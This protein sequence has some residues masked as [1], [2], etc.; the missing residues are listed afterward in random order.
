MQLVLLRHADVDVDLSVPAPL[1]QLSDLGRADVRRLARAPFWRRLERIFTSPEPKALETAQI[2]AGPNGLT[3]TAVEDLREVTRPTLH[4]F[5]ASTYPG[6][7]RGAVHDHLARPD[8]ST[9]GWETPR[10]AQDRITAC[11]ERLHALD[12]L[13]FAIS[14]HGQSLSLLTAA[15]T[16]LDPAAI[17]DT[18]TVPDY[19]VVDVAER[20]LIRGFGLWK[21]R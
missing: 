18:I 17:W 2:I 4:W 9:H 13:P 14:G 5:D 21:K 16:G 19:A 8:H 15:L 11:F 1:W 10:A 7:Y 3:V 20:R 12:S 6:G